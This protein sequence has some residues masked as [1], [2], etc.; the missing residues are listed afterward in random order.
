LGMVVYTSETKTKEVSIRKVM[1]ATVFNVTY[2][3]SK[4]YL[5]MMTWA[6]A[7][8]IPLTA[9]VLSLLL[10]QVQYYTVRLSAFDVIVSM[11]ILL[12]LGLVTITVQTYRTAMTNPANALRAD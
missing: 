9:F 3:L 11:L 2:M 7:L 8:A 10:K 12:S 5:K 1:G 4:D 6:I